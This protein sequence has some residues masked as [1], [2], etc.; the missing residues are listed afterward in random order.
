MTPKREKALTAL[1]NA[2]TIKAA[3]MTAGIDEKTMRGY[4]KDD[5]FRLKYNNLL[6]ERFQDAARQSQNAMQTA[7]DTLLEICADDE[8]GFMC[9]ISACKE[10]LSTALKLHEQCEILKRLSELENQLKEA[11]V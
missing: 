1:L 6:D 10:I 5:E 4:L 2:P 3:A 11:N 7:L 9:R 8:A